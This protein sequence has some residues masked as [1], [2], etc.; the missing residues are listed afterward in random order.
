[1]LSDPPN[2]KYSKISPA[3]RMY[4]ELIM[5][6]EAHTYRVHTAAHP[7]MQFYGNN[8]LHLA[9]AAWRFI[10]FYTETRLHPC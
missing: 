4:G 7:K 5:E 3:E 2:H 9:I 8:S 6:L 10:F 1:M